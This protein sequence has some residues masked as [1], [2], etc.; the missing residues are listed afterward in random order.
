[1]SELA[2]LTAEVRELRALVAALVERLDGG[3]MDSSGSSPRLVDASELAA[4]L[5]VSRRYVYEH[6]GELGAVKLGT[7]RQ[8]RLRFDVEAARAA[9][10]RSQSGRSNG[11]SACSEQSPQHIR[12]RSKRGNT[13]RLPPAGS[14]LPIRAKA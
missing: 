10:D 2:A 12:G 6:A 4:A 1:V 5:G 8:P 11:E 14:V 3:E 7:G 13:P 9:M